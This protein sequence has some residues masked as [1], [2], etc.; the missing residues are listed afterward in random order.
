MRAR[1]TTP[2]A[3]FNHTAE[4]LVLRGRNGSNVS[5]ACRSFSSLRGYQ[6]A[7]RRRTPAA[8]ESCAKEQGGQ[9]ARRAAAAVASRAHTHLSPRARRAA[10][11]RAAA[12]LSRLRARASPA[13]EIERA[14][15]R[16]LAQHRARAPTCLRRASTRS[17]PRC[18]PRR[19]APSSACSSCPCRAPVGPAALDPAAGARHIRGPAPPTAA[20]YPGAPASG[21][22]GWDEPAQA[23]P[24][25]RC[26]S[27]AAYEART[28]PRFLSRVLFRATGPVFGGSIGALRGLLCN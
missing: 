7:A 25:A 15:A 5:L 3:T 13:A 12:R 20:V 1:R 21:K 2:S 24:A 23:V 16:R 28:G 19:L 17:G 26:D 4:T 27:G 11:P 14:V 10:E 6:P 22:R 18:S 9:T 8:Q